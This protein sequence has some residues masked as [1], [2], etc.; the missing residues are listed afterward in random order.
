MSDGSNLL[1]AE[2]ADEEPRAGRRGSVR[3]ITESLEESL[4]GTD[5][6]TWCILGV[7]NVYP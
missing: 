1:G 4:Y 3:T 2:T 6:G 5:R 7:G